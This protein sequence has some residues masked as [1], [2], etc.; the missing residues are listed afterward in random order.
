MQLRDLGAFAGADIGVLSE[1]AFFSELKAEVAALS[2]EVASDL[3]TASCDMLES[4]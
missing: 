3:D 2:G 4:R 1:V